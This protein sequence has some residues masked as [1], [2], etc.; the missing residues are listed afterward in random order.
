[1]QKC[2]QS[3]FSSYI[4]YQSQPHL[5]IQSPSLSTIV[6]CKVKIEKQI[7]YF[8]HTIRIYITISKGR[9]GSIGVD[10]RLKQDQKSAGQTPNSAAAFLSH[11]G[12]FCN[13]F[14]VSVTLRPEA[15]GWSR[16]VLLLTRV[17]TWPLIQVHFHQIYVF[18]G[19]FHCLSLDVLDVAL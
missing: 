12:R 14:F 15:L 1:M 4:V 16:H 18:R 13:F 7:I 6:P 10:T 17:E 19:F 5:K 3:N 9:K 11:K 2:T 8:P